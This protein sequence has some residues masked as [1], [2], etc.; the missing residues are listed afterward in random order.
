MKVSVIIPSFNRLWCLPDAIASCRPGDPDSEIIVIDD[1][2]SDGTWHWLSNQPNVVALR[3]ENA[4]K[5]YAVNR[6]FDLA[7]GEYVRFLDSDDMLMAEANRLQYSVGL[8]ASADIVVAGY[9][10][11]DEE[12]GATIAHPWS[13]CG[14]FLAQQL[15]ECDSS[16]YSAYLFRK[17]F[18]RDIRHRPEF[19]F[20]DDR[21]FVIEAALAQPSVV[22]V[23]EPTLLHRHHRRDRLQFRPG[24]AAI[25]TNWQDLLMFRRAVDM[26][27]ER[28][29]SSPRR[30]RAICNN[31]WPLALRISSTHR[32]EGRALRDWLYT[33]DPGF[34]VPRQ[35]LQNRLHRALGFRAATLLV[36]AA[37]GVRNIWQGARSMFDERKR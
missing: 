2:S 33:L 28:G 30:L 17:V 24:S 1:G 9:H 8:R 23:E 19:S 22:A 7:K 11:W 3:Q 14:D 13:D 36:N 12:S 10:A 5:A 21:M 20:H 27:V 26:V 34:Q 4:G 16:H 25:A 31:L 35:G 32:E 29:L 18:L 37:R 15:G 6:A